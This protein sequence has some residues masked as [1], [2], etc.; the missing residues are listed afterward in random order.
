MAITGGM[1]LALPEET[2]RGRRVEVI[3]PDGENTR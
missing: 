3:A 2:K 1:E